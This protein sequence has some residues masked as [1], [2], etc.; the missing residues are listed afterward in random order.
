M[1]RGVRIGTLG[2]VDEQH[3]AAAADLLHAVGEAGKA[4]QSVLQDLGADAERQRAGRGAC[5]VLGV[6]Q[7]AERTDAADPRD[8]AP[9]RAGRKQDGFTLDIDAVWQ[10][11]SDR[12]ADDTLA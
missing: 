3:L 2:V 1:R 8:L 7:P 11:I 5:R 9:R 6:M 10:W 4:A 12:D